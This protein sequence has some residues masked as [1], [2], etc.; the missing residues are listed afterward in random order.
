MV[1]GIT[2]ANKGSS[3]I[4]ATNHLSQDSNI[5]LAI[6]PNSDVNAQQQTQC[7][8]HIGKQGKQFGRATDF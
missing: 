8:K 3:G 2:P 7:D 4:R 5:G 1:Y 6:G